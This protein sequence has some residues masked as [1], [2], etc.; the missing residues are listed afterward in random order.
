MVLTFEREALRKYSIWDEQDMEMQGIFFQGDEE[1]SPPSVLLLCVSD[2]AAC[3]LQH[4][5]CKL[6]IKKDANN[7]TGKLTAN[8]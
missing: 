1:L 3:A 7:T 4:D 8:L 5:L 2:N 6:S